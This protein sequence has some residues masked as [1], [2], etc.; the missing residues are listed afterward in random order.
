MGKIRLVKRGEIWL[1]RLPDSNDTDIEKVRPA[2]IVQN[3]ISNLYSSRTI[4]VPL[5]S[6]RLDSLYPGEFLTDKGKAL[7]DQMKSIDKRHLIRKVGFF[8][9][10][11]RLDEALKIA[12]DL[13]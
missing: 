4:I 3:D 6:K 10:K 5:T 12:L 8:S 1:V 7:C 13:D 11:W 2:I 9:Q